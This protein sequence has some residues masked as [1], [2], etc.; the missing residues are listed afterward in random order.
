MAYVLNFKLLRALPHQI[1]HYVCGW[2]GFPCLWMARLSMHIRKSE[3][4]ESLIGHSLLLVFHMWSIV[5]SCRFH[6]PSTCQSC[7]HFSL[8]T[9]IPQTLSS[10]HFSWSP[11]N[12]RTSP[13]VHT[14][15]LHPQDPAIFSRGKSDLVTAVLHFSA[16]SPYVGFHCSVVKSIIH[17]AASSSTCPSGLTHIPQS[18]GVQ[19]LSRVRLFVT[20]WTAACQASLSITNSWSLPKLMSKSRWCHLTISSSV[21]PFSCPQSFP[22]SGSFQMSQL[23][24]SGGQN[25]G[26]SASTSVLPMNTQ[27]WSPLGWTD[28]ISF[29]SKGLLRVFS[30]TTVQK[31]QFF[32]AQLSSQSNSHIHTWPLEKP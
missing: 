11:D 21:V 14:H 13:L 17:M 15:P 32:S 9:S 5:K 20:P 24:A 22:T 4:L 27:D 8:S 10:L 1:W 18:P 29:Q 7:L 26:V 28:W 25:T 19:S 2:K 31:H 12:R 3:S 6:H 30:N 16:Q 23:F